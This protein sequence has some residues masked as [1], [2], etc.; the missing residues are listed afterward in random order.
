[1]K[2]QAI[3]V[4]LV[5]A[6]ASCGNDPNRNNPLRLADVFKG[7]ET[8]GASPTPRQLAQVALTQLQEPVMLAELGDGERLAL[9]VPLGENG[10]V[11]T[12]TT[13]DRQ[14]IALRRGRVVA[15]RGLGDDLM[16][17][18]APRPGQGGKHRL[19]TLNAA[20]EPVRTSANCRVSTEGSQVTSLASG[21]RVTA[22]HLVESCVAGNNTYRNEFW[23]GP[24]GQM[25]KSRQWL[26]ATSGYLTLQVLRP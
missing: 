10:S 19:V 3:L 2:H 4:L 15:T 23:I 18:S 26:G 13:I 24:N 21:E 25:R 7:G 11:R 17:S 16:S 14:T 22:R 1:M 9:L 6:L 12:W 20:H 8:E 5:L